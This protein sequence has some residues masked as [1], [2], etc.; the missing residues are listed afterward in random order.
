MNRD[1]VKKLQN[2]K[3]IVSIVINSLTNE[4][5]INDIT[6]NKILI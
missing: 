4:N 3:F 6:N 2:I 1:S 5:I